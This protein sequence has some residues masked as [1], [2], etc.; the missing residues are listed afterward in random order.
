MFVDDATFAKLSAAA[1]SAQIGVASGIKV[2]SARH[3]ANLKI[4]A[5][6]HLQPHRFAKDYQDLVWLL[7]SGKTEL[8]KQEFLELC[9]RYAS[10]ELYRK[11]LADWELA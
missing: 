8:S 7:R 6:K 3:L 4:H 5:L 9:R 11:A 2:V 1:V 10:D